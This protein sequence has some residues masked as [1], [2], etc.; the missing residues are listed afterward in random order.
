VIPFAIVSANSLLIVVVVMVV[1]AHLLLVLVLLLLLLTQLSVH[2][3]S[4]CRHLL[5]YFYPFGS[6]C[7][8]IV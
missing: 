6:E 5:F 2:Y 4:L 7:N 3:L 8:A 1:V